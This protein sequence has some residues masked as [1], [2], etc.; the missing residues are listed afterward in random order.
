MFVRV[1]I[2]RLYQLVCTAIIDEKVVF[3]FTLSVFFILGKC[4]S[5][6]RGNNLHKEDAESLM[7]ASSLMPNLEI[8]DIS[9][10]PIGDNGIRLV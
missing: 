8:L 10:N 5:G 3:L 9:D 6:F 2:C 7:Y 1:C 4:F